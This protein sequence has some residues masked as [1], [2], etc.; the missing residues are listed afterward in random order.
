MA[1]FR[2]TYQSKPHTLD[3]Y[4]ALMWMVIFVFVLLSWKIIPIAFGDSLTLLKEHFLRYKNIY[5]ILCFHALF[6]SYSRY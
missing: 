1:F 4:F 3:N 5:F 6:C 2:K